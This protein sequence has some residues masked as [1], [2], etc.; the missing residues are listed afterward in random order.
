MKPLFPGVNSTA[1][2]YLQDLL[3]GH[4]YAFLPDPRA[5]TYGLYGS[6]TRLAISAYGQKHSLN[7]NKDPA[8][9]GLLRD[10]IIR[11]APSIWTGAFSKA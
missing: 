6:E 8:G 11:P 9:S 7:G 4:G 2:G 5:T 3:R 10:L 1:V